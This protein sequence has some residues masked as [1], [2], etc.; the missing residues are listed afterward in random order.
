MLEEFVL[1]EGRL[2]IGA[3]END[4]M[5][6]ESKLLGESH[7]DAESVM[8]MGVTD[9]KEIRTCQLQHGQLDD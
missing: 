1:P 3:G 5:G 6:E 2:E 8:K 4:D 9:W 7:S